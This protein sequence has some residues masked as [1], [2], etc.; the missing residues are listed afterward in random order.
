MARCSPLHPRAWKTMATCT[1]S[2]STRTLRVCSASS[3]ISTS[4]TQPRPP[5]R[6]QP[7][8]APRS[9]NQRRMIPR[10]TSPRRM[11]PRKMNPRRTNRRRTNPREMTPRRMNPTR[12]MPRRTRRIRPSRSI[13]MTPTC[14]CG[15]SPRCPET[16]LILRFPLRAIACSSWAVRAKPRD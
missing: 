7:S 14:V 4:R 8:A 11:S 15:G 3:R 10:R 9:R 5:R 6:R 1:W 2:S 16:N 12:M 13:L